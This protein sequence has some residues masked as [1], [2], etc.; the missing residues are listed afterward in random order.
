MKNEPAIVARVLSMLRQYGWETGLKKLRAEIAATDDPQAKDTLQFFTGWMAA[1]QGEHK[2]ARAFFVEL[3]N[4]A[5]LGAWALFGLAFVAMR[6][7]DYRACEQ[8]LN[9]AEAVA[10]DDSDL[11]GAIAHLRGANAFHDGDSERALGHLRVALS[12]FGKDH[13]GTGRVLDTFGMVYAGRDNFHAAEE[14]FTQAIACKKKHDDRHGLALSCG[15]LGRL[16][17]DWGHLDQAEAAFLD[18]LT[19]SQNNL[20]RRGEAQ[21]CDHLGQ[22]ALERGL[23]VTA[24]GR[25]D[26]ARERWK[27]ASGWLDRSVD[28][29]IQGKWPVSEAY[30]RKDRA[31]L[32]LAEG[33]LAEAEA[34]AQRAEAMVQAT[35]FAEGLAHI[36]RIWGMLRRH[37]GRLDEANRALRAALAHF[38]ET[39]ERA[40]VARTLWEIAR[41]VQASGSP[42][43]LTTKAYRDALEVAESCRRAD[44][45]RGIGEELKR[46]NAEAYFKHVFHR[47]RGRGIAEDTDSLIEGT[48]EPITVLFL[49]LKDSTPYGLETPAEVV[50]MTLN[51]MMADMVATLR[52]H[53]ALI[54]G[55]RGDGFMAIFRKEHHALRAVSAGVEMSRQM[56][57]FNEPRRFLGLKEFQ[58]RIGISTGPAVLGNVGTYDL[59]DYTAIGTAVNRG[60]RLESVANAGFPCISR[61]TYE[62][63]RGR[64]RYL[65]DCPRTVDLKGLGQQ[66]V[67]DVDPC[68]ELR[69]R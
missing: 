35:P 1:E 28:L 24:I 36:N 38:E 40:E 10:N 18:D 29:S 26:E 2:E 45:V 65:P 33:N 20:D 41:T 37:Q 7:T 34:E 30:A 8:L 27:D 63:V 17:L 48:S 55:F 66:Q 44:L 16:Y 54:S 69:R 68:H 67:W 5:E 62:E 21:M 51:Q 31:R 32:H 13:F 11:R 50:M 64:F 56:A 59:M 43:P 19:I 4:V 49:D 9:E 15:N 61:E 57:D 25:I 39:R 53:D 23:R 52:R 3:R 12:H 46:E 58:I 42:R 47:V 22:V 14:F 6:E 60:A